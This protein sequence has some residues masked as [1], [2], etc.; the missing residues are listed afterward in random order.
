MPGN[1]NETIE[2]KENAVDAHSSQSAKLS[3]IDTLVNHVGN[4]TAW[5][6]PV[7]M[8]AI[9]TQ[10]ILRKMGSNQA[11][12][13]D[14]QWWIYGFAMTVGFVY[15]ITTQSHVRVDILYANFSHAKKSRIDVFGLGWLL[16]PFLLLMTDILI[17]YSW[18]S[19]LVREGS[20]SPNGLH[21]L[22]LL[23]MSLPIIFLLGIF[24]AIS[25][26]RQHLKVFAQ[27]HLWTLMIA[28][29]PAV[30]FVAERFAYYSMWWFIRLMNP[31]IQARRIS[32]EPLLEPTV[33]Y[34][35]SIVLVI[36]AISFLKTRR[37]QKDV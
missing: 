35:L 4:L 20:D 27:L 15:A 22:Y 19:F 31:E 11:W 16:L 25:L 32:R 17:H 23:K 7:L 33:W 2:S 5:L 3:R 12:L 30:W 9:C 10:V 18:T 1:V 34:G 6:F 26:V 37:V 24:A 36:M 29:F 14:A 13:D 8:I 21:H 28:L